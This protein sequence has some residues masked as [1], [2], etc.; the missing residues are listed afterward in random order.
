M[1]HQ[2]SGHQ[3]RKEKTENAEVDSMSHSFSKRK[4]Q[5]QRPLHTHVFLPPRPPSPSQPNKVSL[6]AK[7]HK[8]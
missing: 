7:L 1:S 5:I 6:S 3:K 4:T 8:D 2:K